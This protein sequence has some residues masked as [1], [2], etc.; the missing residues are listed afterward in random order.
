FSKYRIPVRQTCQHACLAGKIA[1]RLAKRYVGIDPGAR[2]RLA[3]ETKLIPN[4]LQNRVELSQLQYPPP[5]TEPIPCLAPRKFDILK[6]RHCNFNFRQV[7]AMQEHCTQ[8]YGWVNPRGKG[9]PSTRLPVVDP[10]PW[11]EGLICQYFVP[12][13]ERSK[14]FQ[15]RI[16]DEGQTGRSKARSSAKKS[17]EAP[18]NLISEVSIHLQQVT[19]REAR[20]RD[21][22]SQPCITSKDTGTDTFAST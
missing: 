1:T 18:Q 19:D 17:Q 12:S 11:I 3:E 16:K 14:R 13:R 22:L 21:A 10:L 5:T 15:V 2:R 8:F 4:V 20:Y 7:Q 6:C 9:R